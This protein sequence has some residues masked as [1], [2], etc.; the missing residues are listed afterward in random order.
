MT[1]YYE[2]CAAPPSPSHVCKNKIELIS[3]YSYLSGKK[4]KPPRNYRYCLIIRV[5]YY[6]YTYIY[7]AD[8]Y[9]RVTLE[10]LILDK[11][12]SKS[13]EIRKFSQIC[14]KPTRPNSL[15]FRSDSFRVREEGDAAGVDLESIRTI[16]TEDRPLPISLLRAFSS[17][18][19]AGRALVPSSFSTPYLLRQ[20]K[21]VII[22]SSHKLE[23][24]PHRLDRKDLH[25]PIGRIE[26]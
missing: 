25:Y 15:S 19:K 16:R 13:K 11:N 4:I 3:I 18:I 12:F 10:G 20:G 26:T 8:T 2:F 23:F 22:R 24:S 17:G 6:E 1:R 14:R 21:L 5:S 7:A 9:T